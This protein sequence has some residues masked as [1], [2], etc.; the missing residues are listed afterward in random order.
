MPRQQSRVLSA[1][2]N[3]FFTLGRRAVWRWTD[4]MRDNIDV[5]AS[6]ELGQDACDQGAIGI[7][8]LVEVVNLM[9]P[10][11]GEP[12][13]F[14]P[15]AQFEQALPGEKMLADD[16][17]QQSPDR[18]QTPRVCRALTRRRS[19]MVCPACTASFV[20]TCL[21]F[22]FG[23]RDSEHRTLVYLNAHCTIFQ[24]TCVCHPPGALAFAFRR[25]VPPKPRQEDHSPFAEKA[26]GHSLMDETNES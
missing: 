10:G 4:H 17:H 12:F 8:D 19:T 7:V 23:A 18:H 22:G 15:G 24:D 16:R 3:Q 25:L 14:R 1:V 5:V 26:W 2:G 6:D 21:R 13:S 20:M 11:P 9:R